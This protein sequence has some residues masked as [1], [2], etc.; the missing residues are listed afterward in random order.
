MKRKYQTTPLSLPSDK[1]AL[2]IRTP[3]PPSRTRILRT[4]FLLFKT[5]FKIRFGRTS[6]EVQ[7]KAWRDF[8]EEL[9]GLW[10]KLGQLLGMRTD[11]YDKDFIKE[12]S[13]LQYKA[14]VFPTEQAI[15]IIEENMGRKIDDVF[16]EFDKTPIGAASLAQVYKARLK[17]NRQEVAVKVQRPYTKEFL[18]S[19]MKI[20]KGLLSL[21]KLIPGTAYLLLDDMHWELEFMLKEEVD[22]RYET[23]NLKEARK[24]FK[25]YGIYVPKVYKRLSTPNLIVMEFIRGIT[26]S[27]FIESK[28][29]DPIKTTL[30]LRENKINPKKVAR[31][32]LHAVYS[33]TFIDNYFHG[34]LQPGNIMLL[35]TGKIALIDFGSIGSTDVEILDVYRQQMACIGEHAYGKAADLMLVMLPRVPMEYYQEIKNSIAKGVR[36]NLLES[37]LINVPLEDKT[38]VHNVSEQMNKALLK[39]KV[40]TNW[41]ILKLGR[42]FMTIDPSFVNLNPDMNFYKE[43]EKYMSTKYVQ[44]NLK[45]RTAQLASLPNFL[46]DTADMYVREQRLKI[47]DR[48]VTVSVQRKLSLFLLRPI[49]W[50]FWGLF[51]FL[52]WTYLY[53]KFDF[54]DRYHQSKTLWTMTAEQLPELNHLS[55][56]IILIVF[57]IIAIKFNRLINLFNHPSSSARYNRIK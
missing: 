24:R 13:K 47:I 19:D 23:S 38:T 9:G 37:S 4:Y 55:S 21:V 18:K 36:E 14:S 10:V 11:L 57:L 49:S 22:L 40:P 39:Y 5:L 27:K 1:E 43:I 30:W 12:L 51:A 46:I 20:I 8:F 48:K 7:G 42:T 35:R 2:S 3:K 26:M 53:Q 33:Q 34:D 29:L 56:I 28:R 16:S 52:G 50:M 15:E 45:K 6:G 44:K 54:L 17:A 32:L 31:Q 25:E 41:Q